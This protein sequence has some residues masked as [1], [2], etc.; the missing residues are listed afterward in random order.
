MRLPL[1]RLFGP[2]VTLLGLLAL[3]YLGLTGRLDLSKLA[4]N[5]TSSAPEALVGPTAPPSNKPENLITIATFN[6]QVFGE[7]KTQ[8][9]EVMA[10]LAKICKLFDVVA[11]QEV[12]SPDARPVERLVGLINADGS[13]YASTISRPIFRQASITHREQYAFVYDTTR[14]RLDPERVYVMNDEEDRMHREPM[15]ASFTAIP[16]GAD[17]RRPFT[18]TL[19]NAHTD[20]DEVTPGAAGDNELDVLADVYIN[21]RNWEYSR[22][23]EDDFILLGDLNAPSDKLYGL[24][25][26]PGLTSVAGPYPTNT[27]GTKTLDHVLVDLETTGEFTR[28]AG[29]V[30]YV[31]DLKL[32]PEQAALISDHRPVWAQF[33]S[34]EVPAYSGPIAAAPATGEAR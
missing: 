4:G 26:I 2:S 17:G 20:P 23:G 27:V 19:I 1:T 34:F 15:V 11:I 25:K 8:K 12:R 5:L 9:P 16:T 33:S 10:D 29:V 6:I 14:I 13:R 28:K 31:K 22:H 3:S 18:F 21:V 30:D 32:S 7:A 24:A